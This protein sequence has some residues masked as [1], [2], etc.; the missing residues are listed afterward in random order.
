MGR[1][2]EYCPVCKK[3]IGDEGAECEHYNEY[4]DYIYPEEEDIEDMDFW[5][6]CEKFYGV[7]SDL[8]QDEANVL[9]EN[10]GRMFSIGFYNVKKGSVSFNCSFWVDLDKV[11]QEYRRTKSHVDI[12]FH[13]FGEGA[14]DK[15]M[16]DDQK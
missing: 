4:L 11:L 9:G 12:G 16:Y 3:M 14:D 5:D 15:Y 8:T 1:D 6:Y 2:W 10:T 13:P 7:K